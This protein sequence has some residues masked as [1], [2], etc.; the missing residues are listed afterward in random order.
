MTVVIFIAETGNQED[1]KELK[2]EILEAIDNSNVSIG[3]GKA[4]ILPEN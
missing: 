3:H 4:T 1:A 2:T